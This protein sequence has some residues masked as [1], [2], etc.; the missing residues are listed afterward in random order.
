[1]SL[2]LDLTDEQQA[3]GSVTRRWVNEHREDLL[4]AARDSWPRFWDELAELGILSLASDD[5]GGGATEVVVALLELGRG[6]CPGPLAAAAFAALV[7]PEPLRSDIGAGSRRA[8]LAF[9][10]LVPWVADAD[11]VLVARE[12]RA[13]TAT[14]DGPIEM[15]DTMA[16]ERWGRANLQLVEG[17][18]DATR[19][20]ALHDLAIGAQ[21]IGAAE[22]LL[23]MAS[24][25]ARHRNQFGRSIGEFQGVAHPLADADAHLMGAKS[26]LLIAASIN[27]CGASAERTRADAARARLAATAAALRTAASAHQV[28]GALGFII[29]G[30]LSPYTY[31]IR[32]ASL[33]PPGPVAC[34][35]IVADALSPL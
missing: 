24:Q 2:D 11:V 9:D 12:G 4:T 29:E 13:W 23:E 20:L 34:R 5:A 14:I 35:A 32:Q 3:L 15:V 25:H 6:A 27:D 1:M 31:L 22:T 19:A 30:G 7:V 8:T 28:Y 10:T 18:G 26:L 33:L 17:L 21:V 16:G